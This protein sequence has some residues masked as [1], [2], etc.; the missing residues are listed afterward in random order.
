MSVQSKIM[1]SI[2]QIFPACMIVSEDVHTNV[3]K[4]YEGMDIA[5]VIEA[6]WGIQ[7]MPN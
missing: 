1:D 4:K 2:F 5:S 3:R 7:L 6:N